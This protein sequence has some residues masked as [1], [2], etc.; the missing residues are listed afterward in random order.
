[1]ILLL[2]VEFSNEVEIAI[3]K[4]DKVEILLGDIKKLEVVSTLSNEN[5]DHLV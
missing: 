5:M 2:S 4:I 1:M 3:K